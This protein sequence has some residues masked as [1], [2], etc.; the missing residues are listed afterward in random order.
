MSR[1]MEEA[2]WMHAAATGPAEEAAGSPLEG[3]EGDGHQKECAV[4]VTAN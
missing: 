2:G 1:D 4:A 3:V